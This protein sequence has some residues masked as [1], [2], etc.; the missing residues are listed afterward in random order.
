METAFVEIQ[1]PRCKEWCTRRRALKSDHLPDAKGMGPYSESSVNSCLYKAIVART[2]FRERE[3][4]C[5][6]L[7]A[8]QDSSVQGPVYDCTTRSEDRKSRSVRLRQQLTCIGDP[9]VSTVNN[10]LGW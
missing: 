7:C 8:T 5:V 4:D 1:K 2:S 6:K 10:G 3:V 9:V